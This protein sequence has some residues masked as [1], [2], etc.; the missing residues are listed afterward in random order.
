MDELLR[1]AM[2]KQIAEAIKRSGANSTEEETIHRLKLATQLGFVNPQD[3][4]TLL[5]NV[6]NFNVAIHAL[7]GSGRLPMKVQPDPPRIIF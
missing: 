1:K 5:A 6:G 4:V 7:A 3:A 2:D